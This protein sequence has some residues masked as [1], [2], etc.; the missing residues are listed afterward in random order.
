MDQS[1]FMLA[2]LSMIDAKYT[3]WRLGVAYVNQ[4]REE[5]DYVKFNRTC[6][7]PS[8][9]IED[10]PTPN[11]PIDPPHL[12]WTVYAYGPDGYARDRLE[13]EEL[14]WLAENLK[15]EVTQYSKDLYGPKGPDY[16][17]NDDDDDDDDND[18]DSGEDSEVTPSYQPRKRRFRKE[19]NFFTG[20][21]LLLQIW[22]SKR[23][24]LLQSPAVPLRQYLPK[25]YRDCRP[26]RAKMSLKEFTELMEC[27]NAMEWWRMSSMAHH[28]LKDNYVP[29]VGYL[30]CSNYSTCRIA[31]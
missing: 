4:L 6:L 24:C 17:G 23:L 14:V 5:F 16:L 2:P 13:H 7:M 18:G 31:R 10:A 22:L 26:K 25:H 8:L 11:I 21:P 12:P 15:L 20:S 3:L 9:S 30:Y 28:S 29:L 27:I 1:K 19:V